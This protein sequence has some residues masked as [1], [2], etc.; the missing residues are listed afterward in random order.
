[1]VIYQV[2]FTKFLGVFVWS[3]ELS[4]SFILLNGPIVSLELFQVPDSEFQAE[5]IIR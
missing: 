5:E 1:M 2:A 4:E 3:Q